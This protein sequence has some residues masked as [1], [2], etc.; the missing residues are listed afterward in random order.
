MSD[1][2]L[3]GKLAV[4]TGATRGLGRAIT[5][6]FL[7]DGAAVIGTGTKPD[8]QVPKGC[9][10]QQLELSEDASVEAMCGT[11]EK[12]APHILVNNAGISNPQ[13]WDTLDAKTFRAT[14]QIDLVAPMMMCRAAI[15][16]MRNH[17]WGRFVGISALSGSYIGRPTRASLG[18]AKAGLVAVYT[19]LAAELAPDGILA[20]CVAP[21]FIDTDVLPQLYTKE[22]IAAMAARAPVGRLGKPE[23]VA[24]LVAFLAG[25]DNTYM[26]GQQ[27][28]IDGGFTR[29][30]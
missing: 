15:P 2:P 6:R 7:A 23:E 21:G 3:Q 24:A 17:K 19:S 28:L 14:Q 13:G 27:I 5:E 10:Y 4:V 8:G 1:K 20:N 22:Q 9:R 16:G 29:T 26:T 25:P 12:E 30:L 18:A 11:I